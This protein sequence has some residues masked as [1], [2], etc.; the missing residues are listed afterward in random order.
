MKFK[1]IVV[2]LIFAI[3]AAFAPISPVLAQDDSE[4]L[5]KVKIAEEKLASMIVFEEVKIPIHTI[6]VDEQKPELYVGIDINHAELPI[7]EYEEMIKQIIG[8]D[9]PLS[10]GFAFFTIS[11]GVD[12]EYPL[13]N[14]ATHI[15]G[16]TGSDPFFTISNEEIYAVWTDTEGV[17]FGRTSEEGFEF[18]DKTK[19]SAA[20]YVSE[21]KIVV[22]G[23]NVYI[24]WINNDY[25][26]YQNRDVFFA[27]SSNGGTTFENPVNLSNNDI[28]SA[29]VNF[30]D[31]RIVSSSDG[32]DI[33]VMWV[34]GNYDWTQV[35]LAKSH[36]SGNSFGP[37][38]N[39][40]NI[41]DHSHP[42]NP[43]ISLSERN[44]YIS[45]EQASDGNIPPINLKFMQ[46]DN[47][48]DVFGDAQTFENIGSTPNDYLF[49]EGRE[50]YLMWF[51]QEQGVSITKSTDYGKTF[52]EP[53]ILGQGAYPSMSFFKGNVFV[54]W[55]GHDDYSQVFFAK[56]KDGS[57]TFSDII[58]L[59]NHTAQTSPYAS[60][61]FPK[62]MSDK[63]NVVIH[64]M[65][66]AD[67]PE[68]WVAISG[69]S[70][71]NFRI[72]DLNKI[73][74]NNKILQSTLEEEFLYVSYHNQTSNN[75][76]INKIQNL[77]STTIVDFGSEYVIVEDLFY[78]YS[79]EG[80]L[81]DW[82]IVIIVIVAIISTVVIVFVIWKKKT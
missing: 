69:D 82:S 54:S 79:E 12:H 80:K 42:N 48:G 28:D 10:V 8:E 36:D 4:L 47:K 16:P 7:Y 23:S 78:D 58:Q 45:W 77:N 9:I 33:Y 17:W 46:S 39:I 71:D 50:V 24:S 1:I 25:D 40:S 14:M 11:T 49:S 13:E 62:T 15:L 66:N 34:V 65:Y 67:P 75:M 74:Q 51:D 60:N 81:Q 5:L 21:P 70:G 3:I 26:N 59:S 63:T 6:K 37:A 76:Q 57:K 64:W 2:T 72:A 30:V 31:N 68:S 44:L 27:K 56:S 32:R 18:S 35:Y 73:T 41:T 52:S 22:S 20:S 29:A 43:Q 19:I 38:R 61:P 53:T 55:I